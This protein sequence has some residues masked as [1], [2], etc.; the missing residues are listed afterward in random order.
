MARATPDRLTGEFRRSTDGDSAR[1]VFQVSELTG[2][3]GARLAQAVDTS[4]IPRIG[5]V[6]PY[7]AGLSVTRV[8]AR[9]TSDPS[10]AIVDVDYAQIGAAAAGGTATDIAIQSDFISEV[11][12]RD[13]NGVLMRTAYAVS[14]GFQVQ[15]HRVSVE[16]PTFSLVFSRIEAAVPLAKV[17]AFSGK[18]NA[19]RFQGQP[20][21]TFLCRIGSNQTNGGHRVSYTFTH[22]AKGW[23]ADLTHQVDGVIPTNVS[24][25]N[26]ESTAQVYER[27]DFGR[28]AL[29]SL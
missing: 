10:I 28:L 18:V 11:T 4:A 24:P 22:N 19:G 17:L 27:A 29:P 23:Q 15:T 8:T 16:R 12:V 6:H 25:I 1:R 26:G 3:A 20:A 2:A 9:A 14:G 5:S 13:I 7:V 21:D